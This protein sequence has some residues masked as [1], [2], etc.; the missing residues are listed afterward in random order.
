[1]RSIFPRYNPDLPLEHQQ[2]FPTQASPTHIPREIINRRP[3][4]P[5]HT[6]GR[7][8]LQSPGILGINA[9]S[10]PRGISEEPVME[11]S[12]NE[13]M[14]QLWKVVN[15]WRVQQSEG[16]TFCMRMSSAAE[17]PVHTLSSATHPFYTLRL[18]PTSTSA[19]MTMLRHDPSKTPKRG[20]SSSRASSSSSSSKPD[21]GI[22]V[23]G[24]TL[25]ETARR[26]PPNDGL[27]A[28]LYPRAASKMVIE[29]ANNANPRTNFEQV[30]AAAEHEC[31]RLVWDEDSRRYYLVHPAVST[32]FVVSIFSSPA[33]S[34]VEY[35]LEHEQLPRNLAR[36]VRDGAGAGFLEVDTGV[37][38][39]IDCF[40]I[41]D[42]AVCALMLVAIEEEKKK[43]IE[44]FEAPPVVAPPSPGAKSSKAGKGKG[45]RD[46][47]TRIEEFE[48]DLE[49]QESSMKDRKERQ[50]KVPGFCGL[51]WM[52]VKCLVWSLTMLF[53]A[54][55]KVIIVLSK[56][57]TR[58]KS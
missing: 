28:L 23:L 36:L 51:L 50:E 49:S 45:R 26:F 29:L 11:P 43:N 20:A 18:N 10:F 57:L 8:P 47:E 44:R 56:C 13:E 33:W 38:A 2:Y 21:A 1:M 34:K 52:L 32:P 24:T 14:K 55:A 15:G 48:M 22:E 12:S 9:G 3:Y 6:D 46:K 30:V 39:K 19:Q 31:G 7:S 58:R 54:T 25:E 4:S 5:N 35:V 27:V 17:E 40:Y 16:R 41:V 37:A 42:V 53:K